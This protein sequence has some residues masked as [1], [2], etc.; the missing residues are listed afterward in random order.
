MSL[1]LDEC[2]RQQAS[3]KVREHDQSVDVRLPEA[4]AWLLVPGVSEPNGALE[5]QQIRLQGSELPAFSS[6][7]SRASRVLM[8]S[9]PPILPR[10]SSGYWPRPRNGS[11]AEAF[12]GTCP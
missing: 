2:Q 6:T 10:C 4:Y 12:S 7:S 5:W 11:K 3:A 9:R 8:Q 1:N